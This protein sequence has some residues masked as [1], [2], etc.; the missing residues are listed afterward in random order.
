VIDW[1]STIP[2]EIL[3]AAWVVLVAA[4]LASILL[5]LMWAT[6]PERYVGTRRADRPVHATPYEARPH[7]PRGTV[8]QDLRLRIGGWVPAGTGRHHRADE[9]PPLPWAPPRRDEA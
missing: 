7:R 6:H 2:T 4:A 8:T 5:V 3:V 1:L 9:V